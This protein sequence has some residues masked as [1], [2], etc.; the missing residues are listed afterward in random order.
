MENSRLDPG[1]V[2]LIANADAV[3]EAA[4]R[5]DE[6]SLP[7]GEWM[8]KNLF[9]SI[10]ST[11]LTVIF[12]L[13]ALLAFRG[14]LNF[15]FSEETRWNAVRTNLRLLFTLAYP[16]EDYARVWVSLGLVAVL[17]GLS[18]G[19]MKT[20]A[21]IS[22][23]KF[24]TWC[25]SGG[26]FIAIGALLREPSVRKNEA[27]LS[28][29]EFPDGT[30]VI[31]DDKG[32]LEDIA[33]DTL[34][35]T[36]ADGVSLL[37]EGEEISLVRESFFD[38]VSDRLGWY[39]IAAILLAIGA[40]IWFG[41]GDKRRRSTF[42]PSIPLA[43]A[44]LGV[45]IS[46]TWWYGWGNYTF[47]DA[48]YTFEPGEKVATTTRDP[49]TL[50]WFLLATSFAASYVHRVG[51]RSSALIKSAAIV[52]WVAALF[53]TYRVLN[54][55]WNLFESYRIRSLDIPLLSVRFFAIIVIAAV[56][57][58]L[59]SVPQTLRPVTIG[60]WLLSP[61]ITFFAILR[62]PELDWDHLWSTDL[63]LFLA[64]AIGGG[65]LMWVLTRPGIG[66]VGR[67][68]AVALVFFAG[69]NWA[70]AFFGYEGLNKWEGDTNAIFAP[71]QWV[72]NSILEPILDPIFSGHFLDRIGFLDSIPL[73]GRIDALGN[74]EMTHMLQ[75]VRLSFLWLGLAALLAPNF[76]GEARQRLRLVYA[77]VGF[78]FIFF[79]LVTVINTPSGIEVPT[80]D[81]AGGFMVSIY[82]SVFTMLASF[83]LGVVLALARTSRLPIF[84]MM[85]T[86]YIEAFRGVPLIT[87]LFFFT[88]FFNLF[89]PPGMELS[90]LAAVTVA[91][92]LFSA[93]YL[94]ENVR[95]GLQSI[96]RGQYEASDALGLTTVQ[97]TTFIVLPQGLRVSIPPLVGQ[98]IGTYKET[99]LLAIV[100]VFDFLLV[101]RANIPAQNPFRG[102]TREGLLFIS[103]VY[104]IGAY[105]MSKY[106][107]RL[108]KQ[109]G[110]GDR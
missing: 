5:P 50:M 84:R 15:V 85:S 98:V 36:D 37:A 2:A 108:E 14:L 65:L 22:L 30:P 59:L 56:G 110:V 42:I 60:V 62:G 77:W 6:P 107:Q 35:L 48:V 70:V 106:S 100:G 51:A 93:A 8:R 28:I 31:W 69:Y 12:G 63:P 49:W 53:V 27:G 52:A 1:T 20:S 61:F 40:A 7:L 17:T 29:W 75:V 97:R 10:P 81:F 21:G 39:L 58:W 68:I 47:A 109:L 26:L 43:L 105:A 44:A 38:A 4:T 74:I 16:D 57:V 23:K 102:D 64:F 24:A 76:I 66:E 78:I 82:V 73:L 3:E 89:L 13:L 19:F 11:L 96:R 101:A 32:T 71:L 104:F 46:S 25:F 41:L 94:A 55:E 9:S 92:T 103:V 34:I 54:G 72:Y 80:E 90:G 33:D 83:P 99:S 18:L 79:L 87:M 91:F 45:L 88:V 95:G 86:A 67:L